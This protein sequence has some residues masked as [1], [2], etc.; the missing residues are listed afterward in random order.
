MKLLS[1]II[2][3][4]VS[5]LAVASQ[6]VVVEGT[7]V[8]RD[9]AKE[10][11]LSKASQQYCGVAVLSDKKLKN[12]QMRD[13]KISV[14]S[15]C[16]VTKATVLNE[17]VNGS[18]Y[19]VSMQLTLEQANQSKRIFN[20]SEIYN[21]FNKDDLQSTVKSYQTEKV[22]G[23]KFIE[24]V[25]DDF[26]YHAFELLEYRK[27]YIT[28]DDGRRLY[29]VVPYAVIWNKEFLDAME[30]T[31]KKFSV[32]KKWYQEYKDLPGIPIR[33]YKKADWDFVQYN[34]TDATR[35]DIIAMKMRNSNEPH[36]K[37]TIYDSKNNILQSTCSKIVDDQNRTMYQI[38]YPYDAMSINTDMVA[39]NY[40]T[41]QINS[42]TT[43]H[44]I[45]LE[46]VAK[47]DCKN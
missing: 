2:F 45:E 13:T 14:Y 41:M 4:L 38:G 46:L 11:A 37:A 24:Q 43:I 30:S 29:V 5:S 42:K 35:Y 15:S 19:V 44:N 26:P 25:M 34:L 16:R 22:A 9:K 31:L 21:E 27:P 36:V 28:E 32:K 17:S 1:A 23:D 39:K 40:V 12:Y 33:F 7:G 3:G 8:T 6:T 18:D 47:K 20:Q 10:D